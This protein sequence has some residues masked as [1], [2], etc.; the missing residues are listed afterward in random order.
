ML[1]SPLKQVSYCKLRAKKKA[2]MFPVQHQN[3]WLHVFDLQISDSSLPC[4]NSDTVR[5]TTP[6]CPESVLNDLG[7]KTMNIVVN[8][9]IGS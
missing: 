3:C 2:I 8:G 6:V 5:D 1:V 9:I 7:K 4:C